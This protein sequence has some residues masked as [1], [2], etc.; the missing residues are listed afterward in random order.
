MAMTILFL[1]LFF[2]AA[3]SLSFA[4]IFRA[5]VLYLLSAHLKSASIF[6]RAESSL[7]LAFDCFILLSV[8]VFY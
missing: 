5:A 1:I 7:S 2:R 6:F 4:T 8:F 3:S